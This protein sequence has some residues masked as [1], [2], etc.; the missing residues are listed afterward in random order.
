[1]TLRRN[2]ALGRGM[3]LLRSGRLNPRNRKRCEKASARNFGDEADA[4][5]AMPCIIS[6]RQAVPAHVVSRGASGGRFDIIPLAPDLHQ[7]QHAI[8]IESFAAKYGLDL[9]AEADRIAIGHAAPLGLRPVAE[10][11]LGSMA[12]RYELDALF[13]FTRRWADRSCV[14][15]MRGWNLAREQGFEPN[16]EG[17]PHAINM[18]RSSYHAAIGLDP[19]DSAALLAAAG[20]PP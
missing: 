7:E 8:G 3:G 4:V 12:D 16:D 14:E 5:R 1:M 11:W 17:M 2:T 10:R 13:A 19:R 15:F 6:G 18:V 9:R 20:W